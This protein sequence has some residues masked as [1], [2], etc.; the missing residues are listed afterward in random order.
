MFYDSLV[1]LVDIGGLDEFATVFLERGQSV[2]DAARDR[3]QRV[4]A[5]CSEYVLDKRLED[6]KFC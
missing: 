5:R 1:L 4:A 6:R 2:P 3:D